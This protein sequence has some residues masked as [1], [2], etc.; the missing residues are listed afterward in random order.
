M[1]RAAFLF[2]LLAPP[3]W[4]S[5]CG[6]SGSQAQT[7][8][9]ANKADELCRAMQETGLAK[10][11]TVSGS[12]NSVNVVIDTDDDEKARRTCADLAARVAHL[13][14]KFPHQGKLKMFSPYRSDKLL[15]T[16]S[17]DTAD[18]SVPY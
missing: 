14:E 1:T 10:Q 13:A 9:L 4:I 8:E 2:V 7:P 17:L 16:C 11:C 5:G 6:K 3:L 15:A 18:G 12:D